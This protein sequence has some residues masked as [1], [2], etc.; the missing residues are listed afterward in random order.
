MSRIGDEFYGPGKLGSF[1]TDPRHTPAWQKI[2]KRVVAVA[3]AADL[4]CA[5][6]G[7]Q[8]DYSASGRTPVG[9]SV[10][11]MYALVTHPELAFEESLLRVVHT[12][13]NA[14][15]GGKLGRA[16]E[17]AARNGGVGV[18]FG[19]RTAVDDGAHTPVEV[20]AWRCY[21][22]AGGLASTG[23]RW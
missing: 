11:H 1:V 8:I 13:C 2:R 7:G 16:R 19:G 3:R 15:L 4:P 6:C 12:H 9:P 14:S 5:R 20:A 21:R 17:R 22:E 18:R 23:W 10:D